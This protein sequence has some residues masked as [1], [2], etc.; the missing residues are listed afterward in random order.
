MLILLFLCRTRAHFHHT[1]ELCLTACPCLPIETILPTV[2]LSAHWC[3]K[4]PKH[5]FNTR[6]VRY[7]PAKPSLKQKAQVSFICM[8]LHNV[9]HLHDTNNVPFKVCGVSKLHGY[10]GNMMLPNLNVSVTYSFLHIITR[11]LLRANKCQSVTTL[12]K[13]ACMEWYNSSHVLE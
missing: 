2:P 8:F 3:I 11:H 6:V 9:C 7:H 12:P 13:R 5:V 10:T 1:V 4:P